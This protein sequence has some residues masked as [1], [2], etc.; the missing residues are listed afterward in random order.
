MESVL[1]QIGKE[2][3]KGARFFSF[4]DENLALDR[5]WLEALLGK[6]CTRRIGPEI[7]LST[8]VVDEYAALAVSDGKRTWRTPPVKV[9]NTTSEKTGLWFYQI[10][11][12]QAWGKFEVSPMAVDSGL[13]ASTG[14][15]LAPDLPPPQDW[16]LVVQGRPLVSE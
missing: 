11:E 10:G 12:H 15:Y 13:S 3:E 4:E 16:V 2:V 5:K 9:S 6:M 14:E 7:R 8:A 1:K